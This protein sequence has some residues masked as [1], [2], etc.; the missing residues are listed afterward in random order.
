MRIVIAG[1]GTGGHLFP[2]IAIAQEF[3]KRDAENR[4]IFIGTGNPFETSVLADAGF[5]QMRI[6]SEGIKGRSWWQKAAALFKI[7]GGILASI[8]ILRRFD[9]DLVIGVGGYSSGPVV[10]GAW[11][12]RIP[13]VLHEQNLLPGI[14][15]RMLAPLADRI[16]GSFQETMEFFSPKKV[17]IFGNPVRR[18]FRPSEDRFASETDTQKP[19]TVLVMGGSQGARSINA[20]MMQAV[21]QLK[22]KDRFFFIHQTGIMDEAVVQN[23]YRKEGVAGRVQAFFMDMASQFQEADLVVCRAGATTVAEI[24]AMGKAAIYI[25]FPYAADNHQ[26]RNAETLEKAG[27]AEMLLE[28]DLSGPYLAER[29]DYYRSHS[30]ALKQMATSARAY[31]R[32]DAAA[33]IVSDCYTLVGNP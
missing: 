10:V 2:G 3:M 27:A 22:H 28:E 16:Y 1:G 24:T 32:P 17:R 15:N 25:P 5:T 9:P 21:A 13:I 4:V 26:V 31:G 6:R 12:M 8:G 14:T 19:F 11:L 30:A 23:A 20:A 18:A 29:I 7:P 33:D